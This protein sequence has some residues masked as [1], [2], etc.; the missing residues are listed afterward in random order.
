MSKKHKLNVFK[1]PKDTSK[2]SEGFSVFLAGAIDMG[3]A[4]DWQTSITELLTKRNDEM[5]TFCDF[6]IYNPRRDDWDSSWRQE[7][8]DPKFSEQVNW[9]LDHLEKADVIYLHLPKDSKAPISLLEMGLFANTG[10]LI[11]CC[12]DGFY[13]KGNVDIVCQRYNVLQCKTIQEGVNLIKREYEK[14]LRRHTVNE[15]LMRALSNE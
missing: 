4:V 6:H 15:T 12:E 7:I 9:E 10:K 1:A 13:R 8:D 14:L 5:E 3:S 11:V 2:A